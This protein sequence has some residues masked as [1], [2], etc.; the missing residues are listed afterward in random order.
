MR[1]LACLAV[2]IALAPV[3]AGAQVFGTQPI[4][5]R[6][7]GPPPE[8]S[9]SSTQAGSKPDKAATKAYNNGM[10]SLA[11]AHDLDDQLQK[12]TDAD[13]RAKLT[14]KR[15]DTYGQALDQFTEAIRNRPEMYDAWN[16]V[17][18][19][20]LHFGAYRESIDDYDH[21][22]KI[23]PDLE[24]AIAHQAQ[25]FL[26]TDRLEEVKRAY[27]E[28][29]YHSRPFADELMVSMQDWL[30]KHRLAANGVRPSDI[31]SFDKWLTERSSIAKTAANP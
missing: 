21:A 6:Q 7:H 18:F 17:G 29:F 16:H 30:Q 13:K 8:E 10:K 22:L 12:A 24:E 25:A 4:G 31:D 9:T 3:G 28:L 14:D 5:G 27:M 2:V 26:A 11:K 15:D 19:I 23:K 20:H 1:A